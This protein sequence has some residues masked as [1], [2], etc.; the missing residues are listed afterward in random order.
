MRTLLPKVVTLAIIPISCH[1]ECANG[2]T[3]ADC[4]LRT[5]PKGTAFFD[6]AEIEDTAHL[7]TTCSG[8]GQCD[9]KTGECSC[10]AGYVGIACER[11]RCKNDCS[12]RG[13]CISMRHLADFERN[14]ESLQYSYHQWDADKLYGCECDFGYAGYDCSNRVC[15]RGDDP[16]TLDE[17]DDEVQLLRCS[18]SASSNGH[19]VLYFD[20]KASSSIPASSSVM[21]LKH[22][23]Q[24]IPQI[25][26][27]G[28][29]Y[30]TGSTLCRDDGMDNIVYITFTHNPGPLPPL[31]AE[32]FDMDPDSVVEIAASSSF[33]M[34][35]DYNGV[36][37][38]SVKGNKENEECSNRGI[39]DQITGSC[40]CFDTNGDRYAGN[41]CSEVVTSPVT[42]CPGDPVC[43]DRGVCDTST[44]RC[45]CEDGYAGGDCSQRTCPRGLSWFGYPSSNDVA[46]DVLEECSNMGTCQRTTGECRCNDG[47]FGSACEYMGCS[48][49]DSSQSS[50]HGNGRCISLRELALNHKSSDGTSSPINYGSDANE[51]STF[52]ADRIFGCL[53]DDGY[54]GFDCALMICPTGVDPLTDSTELHECSNKGL[55]DHST[56]LCKCSAGWGSSNGSGSYGPKNDCGRRQSLRGFP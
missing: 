11:T 32:T 7:E 3:G 21:T 20:G 8:R 50:C 55:C 35:T 45:I 43:S 12:R 33:G 23:L 38:F 49:D 46:H 15:P 6:M 48:G 47:F 29:S 56:G 37:H 14:H 53:C 4:S 25:V 52:D 44:K 1:G 19:F 54:G 16:L 24:T 42:T 5:C 10:A 31:V 13:T 41:D 30:T 26:D 17:S 39:C 28:V 40:D 36:N 27:V 51:P 2:F 18:A 34:L 9:Y 22:A